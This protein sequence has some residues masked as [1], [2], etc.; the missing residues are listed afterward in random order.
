MNFESSINIYLSCFLA[1]ILNYADL[2]AHSI[3]YE[4][5]VKTLYH[6]YPTTT[7]VLYIMVAKIYSLIMFI[8]L[9]VEVNIT[10]KIPDKPFFLN[11]NA[12]IRATDWFFGWEKHTADS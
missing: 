11:R 2:N 8:I 6:I 7:S 10:D 3:S 9:E 1:C 5:T 12:K 4:Q